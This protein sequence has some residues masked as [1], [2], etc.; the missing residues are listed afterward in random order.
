M[1]AFL[2]LRE[3]GVV[4]PREEALRRL[5]HR[6]RSDRGSPAA[7]FNVTVGYS[8]CDDPDACH[9]R[10]EC[11]A[12]VELASDGGEN[13]VEYGDTVFNSPAVVQSV[14][15]ACAEQFSGSRCQHQ[16]DPCDP[17]P[18][19]F[20]GRCVPQG[21]QGQGQGR[22]SSSSSSSSSFQCLCPAMR[23]GERCEVESEDACQPNPCLNGGSCKGSKTKGKYIQ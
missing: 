12:E 4:L 15:C 11:R 3:N 22:S 19:L 16:R 20:G 7:N 14:H 10:G 17:S 23:S 13:V 1:D 9:G 21:H 6:F 2:A 5:K 18:C 8:P